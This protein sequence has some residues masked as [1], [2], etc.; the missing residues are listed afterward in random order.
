[1]TDASFRRR[2]LALVAAAAMSGALAGCSI[3]SKVNHVVTT[4]SQN[5]ATIDNFASKL[6]QGKAVPFAATYVTT[7]S[8]PTT[9]VYAVRPPHH[10]A[11][12][13]V[14]GRNPNGNPSVDLIIN[15]SGGYACS[16]QSGTGSGPWQCTKLASAKQAARNQVFNLYTPSHWINFLLAFSLAA[17]FAGDKVTTSTMSVNGFSL[18]C[19]DLRAPGVQGT[20]T[21]CSTSAGILGYV[22]VAKNPQVFEIKSYTASPPASYFQLPAGA[23]IIRQR[24]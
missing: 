16:S 2:A 10:V 8:T 19:V 3:V 14:P 21:I 15:P 9:V 1:M 18:N 22:K 6:R 13:E 11:F 4:V 23:K 24:G 20:S 17:G 7:G 5:K 12:K